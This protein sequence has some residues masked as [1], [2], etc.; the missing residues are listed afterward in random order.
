MA[1]PC[2]PLLFAGISLIGAVPAVLVGLRMVQRG[3][4][5]SA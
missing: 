3:R 4:T 2:T 5:R 1:L